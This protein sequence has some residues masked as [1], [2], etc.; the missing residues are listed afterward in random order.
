MAC[1]VD[2]SA[3]G[4]ACADFDRVL[5]CELGCVFG[6][7]SILCCR[8]CFDSCGG[9]R[10]LWC[11]HGECGWDMVAVLWLVCGARRVDVVAALC[12]WCA[13]AICS[14]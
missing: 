5:L 8:L 2:R 7:V 9:W 13:N 10:L 3:L 4:S 1:A 14:G 12:G 6:F 11:R